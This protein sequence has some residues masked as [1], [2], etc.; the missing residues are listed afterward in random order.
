MFMSD[1]WHYDV[2][3][4]DDQAQWHA[5]VEAIPQHDIFFRPEYVIHFERLSGEV[6][7]L[8]FF[9]D[10]ANY[11]VYPFFL[12]RINDLPFYQASPLDDETEYFDIV[13]P[14]GYSGP[15][16]CVRDQRC[17]RD[18]WEGYLSAFH[19]YCK[20]T[21]IVC[22]FARLNPFVS[23][24]QYLQELTGGVQAT[25]QIVYVD[26]T[27]SEEALWQ[28]LNRGNRSNINKAKR[29]G[30]RVDR[31]SDSDHVQRFYQLY[32]AT[33]RRNHATGWY[34]F[35]PDFF[36][37]SFTFLGDKISLFCAS[38]QGQTIAA[39]SFLHDGDVVHYF[40]GGSDSNYLALRPNNLLMYQAICWAKRQGYRL[41]NLGGNYRPNDSLARFKAAFSKLSTTFYTYRMIHI[42]A[43]YHEL[44]RGHA[45]YKLNM[46]RQCEDTDYFPKY[47]ADR[48]C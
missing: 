21:N 42:P 28:G 5:L 10:E 25:G 37:D 39:A 44:C 38:Y 32:V 6:A 46:G 14:Y 36:A 1:K 12:R 9:G 45:I 2:L 15:L 27:G 16:A 4:T 3:T 31:C 11:I 22:E 43:I 33:M 26:L 48:S 24:Q 7:R 18:L 47:R 35:S 8:F 29:S 20:E 23:N 34:Y 17:Q 30:V 40:L 13:S 19:G 41:F